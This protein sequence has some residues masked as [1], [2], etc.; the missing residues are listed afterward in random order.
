LVEAFLPPLVVLFLAVEVLPFFVSVVAFLAEDFLTVEGLL[1]GVP[2]LAG[3][4][5][6]DALVGDT[7]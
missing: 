5:F 6:L 1:L 4:D 2:F 7:S 3:E